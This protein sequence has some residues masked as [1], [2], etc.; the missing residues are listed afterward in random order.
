MLLRLSASDDYVCHE[1]NTLLHQYNEGEIEE[2]Y[3]ESTFRKNREDNI[4]SEQSG[5]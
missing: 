3:W 5:V 1:E 2:P 4:Q